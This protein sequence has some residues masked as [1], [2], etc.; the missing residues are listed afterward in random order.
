MPIRPG[1]QP[2]PIA[3]IAGIA[4]LAHAPGPRPQLRTSIRTWYS[5]SSSPCPSCCE[6]PCLAID[7]VRQIVWRRQRLEAS[8]EPVVRV[9]ANER[10]D[11]RFRIAVRRIA[12]TPALGPALRAPASGVDLGPAFPAVC[13]TVHAKLQLVS[14]RMWFIHLFIGGLVCLFRVDRLIALDATEQPFATV[15]NGLGIR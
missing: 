15:K 1:A 4:G 6:L 9:S 11:V 3:S 5:S 14:I 7:A 8:T 10:D 2:L 13:P 12:Q